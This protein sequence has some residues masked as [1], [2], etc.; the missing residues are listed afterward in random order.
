MNKK[1]WLY[2]FICLCVLSPPIQANIEVVFTE[3]APTDRF[4]IKNLGECTRGNLTME[5]DLSRSVGKLLFDT[6][7]TGSG[8]NVFQPFEV[9]DSNSNLKLTRP[10]TDGDSRLSLNIA[11]LPAKQSVSFTIDVDDTLTNSE[12]RRTRISGSEIENGLVTI[13]VDQSTSY[14]GSFERDSTATILL[15]PCIN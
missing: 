7:G 14:E 5:F 8:E 4:T 6:V 2:P 1:L 9:A 10:V 3:S 15:P 13:T 12:L 11:V